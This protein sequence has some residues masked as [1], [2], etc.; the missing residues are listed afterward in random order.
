MD[1]IDIGDGENATT[2]ANAPFQ[3][4]FVH[5]SC[6][7][8]QF[9]FDE[10]QFNGRL[11]HEIEFDSA[12]AFA[13][14]AVRHSHS[15]VRYDLDVIDGEDAHHGVVFALVPV[16]VNLSPDKDDVALLE[17]QFSAYR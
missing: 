14:F 2:L 5:L 16:L 17:R 6:D 3:P 15:I 9:P 8:D 11:S 7:D 12:F 10:R 1:D 13:G 4:V